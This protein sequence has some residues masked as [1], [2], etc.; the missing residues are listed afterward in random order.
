MGGTAYLQDVSGVGQRGGQDPRHH[1]TEHVDHHGFIC[2]HTN[3]VCIQE[4]YQISYVCVMCVCPQPM[5]GMHEKGVSEETRFTQMKGMPVRQGG[6]SGMGP[7]PSPMDQHSQGG[8]GGCGGC[9]GWVWW[10]WWARLRLSG[11]GKSLFC[12]G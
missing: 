7:P 4:L 1:T 8:C 10:V 11:R 9:G 6:H 3:T 2:T 12:E 5:E